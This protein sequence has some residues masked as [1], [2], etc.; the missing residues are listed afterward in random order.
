MLSDYRRKER[1]MFV[2]STVHVSILFLYGPWS[3]DSAL[4]INAMV[5]GRPVSHSMQKRGQK[6]LSTT[7]FLHPHC[8]TSQWNRL[9][10]ADLNILVSTIGPFDPRRGFRAN[11]SLDSRPGEDKP[12]TVLR[13]RLRG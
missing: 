3:T 12:I 6:V 9:Y 2:I 7:T 11:R 8:R 5:Q 1:S 10:A 4:A 13:P